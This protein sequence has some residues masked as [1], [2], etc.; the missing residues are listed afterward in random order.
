MFCNK[1]RLV[2]MPASH[3]MKESDEA[4]LATLGYKQE[5]RRTFKPFEIFGVAFSV[6]GLLPSIACVVPSMCYVYFIL[7]VVLLRSSVLSSAVINGGAV[8][9]VWGW[10]FAS[11]FIL[12]IGIALAEVASS[13]PTS[14]GLYYLTYKLSSPR[15]RNILC[16][17]V[18]CRQNSVSSSP[19]CASVN[20]GCTVQIG[21]AVS[22]GTNGQFVMT[23][24][25]SYGAYAAIVL[26]QA[27]ICS[28][29]SRLLARLQTLYIGCNILLCLVII[30]AL[31]VAT[32]IELRNPA[33]YVFGNFTNS[34]GWPDV[35]AFIL[36]LL[37][38]NW[39]IGCYDSVIHISEESSNAATAGPWGM[40]SLT[41]LTSVINVVLAFCM[42]PNLSNLL[43][44]SVNQPLAQIFLSSFGQP[45]AL[46]IWSF[47]ILV[48]YVRP[49]AILPNSFHTV[50]R[51]MTGSTIVLVASRQ[52]FAF[53][54]DG[55]L[56]F[57]KLLYKINRYTGTPVNT[58]WF[59]CILAL[60][61]GLLALLGTT[62]V[63]AVFTISVTAP[64][65]AYVIPIVAR[66]VFKNNF[67]PGP[68]SV[69]R[70]GGP[71]AAI[72]V[73]YMAFMLVIFCFPSSP[74]PDATTMN[75]T[76]VVLGGVVA[77][78]L[79][80]YYFP[81]YGGVYWFQGPTSNLEVVASSSKSVGNHRSDE[82]KSL[83]K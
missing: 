37:S 79:V 57:S 12:C 19:L 72:A 13:A 7:H 81:V 2:T 52:S 64:Y 6:I 45:W 49:H 35:F 60:L 28:L 15:Y 5:F 8:S 83:G 39:T 77:L 80:W 82:E 11:L 40:V 10:A 56:P 74:G 21:A 48:Q 69:G 46:V 32:P 62:A 25:Q 47:V 22:I 61:V 23:S 51:Y 38:P 44:S 78:S 58:V 27:I 66:F 18:G 65:V 59:D 1:S 50:I 16:W 75:Y 67:K 17:I 3:A 14:G 53:A 33:S 9:M 29:G 63:N 42:G 4:V 54:R 68:F 43:N 55:A 71:I 30:F 24:Q 20:W 73:T 76:S 36:G 34:S 41:S 31:P 26:S 70:L